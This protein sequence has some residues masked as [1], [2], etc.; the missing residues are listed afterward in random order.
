MDKLTCFI[1]DDEI[2]SAKL[3]K[4]LVE[5]LDL[6]VEI[7]RIY[8]QPKEALAD[9]GS[10]KPD[11]IF[12]DIE[13][14][15]MNGFQFLKKMSRPEVPIIFVTGYANYAIDA[16]KIAAIDYLIKPVHIE[17]LSEAIK[18]V[19]LRIGRQNTFSRNQ[20]L[21]DNINKKDTSTHTI[22]IPSTEGID[23]V[24]ISKI[25]YC[26]GTDRY[27]KVIA[28]DRELI[29]SSYNLGKF[30][31]LLEDSSFYQVHRSFLINL[32]MIS[33]YRKEGVVKLID[34]TL[35][36]VARRRKEEF[37]NQIAHIGKN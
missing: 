28:Q 16:I 31:D 6:N 26:E 33:Q 11:F 15:E 4:L 37:L 35:I 21:L 3:L 19:S 22:G 8:H 13:M 36:P 14:P 5:E 20:V 9:L 7:L 17:E 29:L 25:L 10:I 24:Q 23:F 32:S 34:G 12:L 18:K 27:T 1:I 30:K 2:K